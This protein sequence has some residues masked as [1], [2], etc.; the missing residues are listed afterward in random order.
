MP[1]PSKAQIQA[2]EGHIDAELERRAINRYDA[3]AALLLAFNMVET[4]AAM[5]PYSA[6][7]GMLADGI[8]SFAPFLVS[9]RAGGEPD[10]AFMAE[11]LIFGFHYHHLR[12]LL[13]YSYNT[14]GAIDWTFGENSL[15]LRFQDRTI[16]RQF[17]T[18]WNEHILLS[19]R[20]FD[21]FAAP[22]EIKRLLKNQSEFEL[23]E[24]H[25]AID[26]LLQEHADR[27]LAAYFS[28][29]DPE[30]NIDL[31]GYSYRECYKVYRVL[32]IKALYH[33]YQAD[34][35]GNIG[36]VH[37]EVGD[38]RE[39]LTSETGIPG[40]TVEAILRDLVYD[41][42]A[43][44]E[45]VDA[46]YFS[47]MKEG[48]APHRIMMRPYGFSK[49]EGLVGLLRVVAKR[50]PSAFLSNVSDVLGAQF[51]QRV[52]AAFEAQGFPC[53]AEVSLR[54]IDPKLPD[55]DLL[56]IVE[57]PTL[58]FVLLICEV[59]SPIPPRWAKDQLRALAPD[60]VSK[61]F[62]QTE[63]IGAFLQTPDGSEFIR[64][65]VPEGG[66]EHFNSFVTVIQQ[67]IITS[68]NA[69]MFFGH[70]QTPILNFRTLERLLRRSDGD[71]LHIRTCISRYNEGADMYLKTVMVPL[72]ID[73]L[74][75]S[76][77]GF[78][79]A[80]LVDFPQ[81]EWR[82]SPDRQK[83]IDDFVAGG[84]HPFDCLAGHESVIVARPPGAAGEDATDPPATPG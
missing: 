25:Q 57:E 29:L 4:A 83:L 59:K 50:R 38:L 60:N 54:R 69:G 19:Q 66:L 40:P 22:D 47:L 55:I 63:A 70:E 36:C 27:K 17:F 42:E 80:A 10:V 11:D 23:G 79:P 49:G 64:S 13:Y 51:V 30:A 48:A 77:E 45:R 65:V 82:G 46:T 58:G 8:D 73:G 7:E 37:M 18:V 75:I 12:D 20:T 76:Y 15:E 21:G 28:I 3:N 74:S 81:A 53:R 33:R 24:V 35:N 68:D 52:K 2:F 43:V 67:L 41:E 32:M 26:P 56:V 16:P 72:E 62:R 9:G 5:R 14:P 61:A 6:S 71:I 39:M 84:H 31:G 34:V 1:Q 44:R 78:T